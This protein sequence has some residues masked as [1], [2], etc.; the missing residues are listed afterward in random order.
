MNALGM[1][2]LLP[3]QLLAGAQEYA[4]FLRLTIR[5]EACTDQAVRQQFRQPGGIAYV[6]LAPFAESQ[7]D[8]TNRPEVVVGNVVTSV[9]TLLPS[10]SRIAATTVFL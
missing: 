10:T 3:D 7:S 2:A 5:D 6:S 1:T 4:H 8:S 9:M